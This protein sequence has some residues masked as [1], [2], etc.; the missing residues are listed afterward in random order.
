MTDFKKLQN[1]DPLK[2]MV[3][4]QSDQEE[5]SP[6]DPPESPP[7]L[8]PIPYEKMPIFLQKF[9]DEHKACLKE[10]AAFEQV[11][12]KLQENGLTPNQDVDKGLRQFFSFLDESILLH[13]LKEEKILFPL[14]QERLLEM[15][16][17]SKGQYSKTAV[18]MLEDDHI[19]LMQ[20]AA[21]T[22]NLLGLAA[23]LPEAASRLITLDA[24]LQQGQSLVELIRLHIDREDNVV[25]SVAVKYL[26][27]EEF[28]E[29]EKKLARFEHY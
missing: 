6:M 13:N 2:R 17:H 12:L 15:G 23:R 29:M 20:T 11:L 28:L 16:E 25:F 19:K 1:D 26:S 18:D 9:M 5:Y 14:L 24:A 10:L 21:V 3:E 8:E 4:K 22:F 27:G 7:G